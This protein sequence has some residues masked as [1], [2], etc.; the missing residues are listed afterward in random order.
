MNREIYIP[1]HRFVQRMEILRKCRNKLA[2]TCPNSK[3]LSVGVLLLWCVPGRAVGRG[4]E[5]AAKAGSPAQ[6]A[7]GHQAGG[8]HEGTTS[9]EGKRPTGKAQQPEKETAQ[10]V[11]YRNDI[12]RA[13]VGID[14]LDEA[15]RRSLF[16]S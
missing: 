15:Q 9:R 8:G 1:V 7:E 14:V 12:H 4:G 5:K 16:Q 6:G 11:F 2:E 10:Q 3:P 13:F